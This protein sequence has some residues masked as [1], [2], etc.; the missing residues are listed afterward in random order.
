MKPAGSSPIL[1]SDHLGYDAQGAKAVLL[2]APPNAVVGRASI[3]AA[4]K[5]IDLD[6]A[7]A[8]SVSGWG[9]TQYRRI[10][11]TSVRVVGEHVVEVEVDDRPVTARVVIGADRLVAVTVSDIAAAFRAAR[12]SGEIDRKDARARFYADDS[13]AEVDARGGW[14]DASG[15]FSKFLSHLTYTRMMSPQQIPLCAWAM[16]AAR[17]ALAA[18]HPHFDTYQ[19]ARLRDEGLFGA[20]FLMR[21]RSPDGYFY[22][23]IFD[24]LTKDLN[25]RVITAPL[26]N[27]VRTQRWQAAYRHGG[28][29]AIAAL[30]RAST[31]DTHGEHSSADYLRAAQE[32][33]EHLEEHNAEYLFDG[34]ESAV[35]DYCALLAATELAAA[36]GDRGHLDAAAHRIASLRRRFTADSSGVGYL[37]GDRLGRPFFH[38]AES[39]LPVVALMRFAELFQGETAA[40]EA[41]A[42]AIDVMSALVARTDSV[43]NPFGYP[44]QL[45]H[46]E[47]ADRPR[48]AFFFPHDNETGYWWQGENANLGS[49]ATA[50]ALVAD[51]AG[52]PPELSDRLRRLGADCLAWVGGLNPFD[53][54]MLQGRGRNNVEYLGRYQNSPGAIV[55]GITSHPFDEDGIAFLPDEAADGDEWRW[56]EQWIPHSA[57]FLLAV[58]TTR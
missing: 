13:G 35:D 23:A 34:V 26:Q 22:T 49:V 16:L 12:S 25:E 32:G 53:S 18:R 45:V 17:D 30:A 29:L 20:D 55:N 41:T 21:F 11:F 52:C 42:L 46:D 8:E 2:A 40:A 6:V 57:W 39:G 44:R 28:G 7:S 51:A 24:A 5:T 50:A 56:A 36:S 58:C 3:V 19:G 54:C 9:A 10:D 15:D 4:G 33:F 47:H 43:P 31:L 1:L 14:L 38:A 27:S 48:E 37:I